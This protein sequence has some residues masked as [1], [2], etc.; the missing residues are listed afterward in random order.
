MRSLSS[1][2]SLSK[3]APSLSFKDTERDMYRWGALESNPGLGGRGG[4]EMK[5]DWTAVGKPWAV[6]R[7]A[8]QSIFFPFLYLMVSIVKIFLLH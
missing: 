8:G 1:S 2:S 7:W 3:P 6:G 5:Q 4:V